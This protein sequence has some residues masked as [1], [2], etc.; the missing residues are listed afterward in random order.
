ME[1]SAPEAPRALPPS[2][3]LRAAC[4]RLP[5]HCGHAPGKVLLTGGYLVLD[6]SF[7]GM[8]FSLS[9]RFHCALT[10]LASAELRAAV[11][12]PSPARSLEEERLCVAASSS[13]HDLLALF[14]L[15]A[16]QR[17]A[18][19]T[20]YWVRIRTDSGDGSLPFAGSTSVQRRPLSSEDN[21]FVAAALY[22]G[23]HLLSSMLPA[24]L[25][26][27]RLGAPLLLTVLGDAAF[28]TAE[29]TE[30]VSAVAPHARVD[31]KTGLGS[32]A[33]LVAS[34]VA[35]LFQVFGLL[36]AQ[37]PPIVLPVPPPAMD[38]SF[39]VVDG[40]GDGSTAQPSS[41]RTP[42]LSGLVQSSAAQLPLASVFSAPSSLPSSSSAAA[43]LCPPCALSL[44][45]SA[46]VSVA[47][48]LSQV[49]HTIA[50][51]KVGSGFDVAA[52]FYGSHV[53]T[54]FSPRCIQPLLDAAEDAQRTQS[55]DLVDHRIDR[56]LLLRALLPRVDH[57]QERQRQQ[58][59]QQQQHGGE[60]A[61]SQQQPPSS[62]SST[63]SS[64]SLSRTPSPLMPLQCPACGW[65][66][67]GRVEW[68][69]V[70]API[71]LPSFLEL[72]LVDV[73]GGAKTPSMVQAVLS[74]RKRS[75]R[76]A[77]DLWQRLSE[78]VLEAEQLLRAMQRRESDALQAAARG[79]G[80]G[81]ALL[82]STALRLAE[83]TAAQ[84]PE[85][86]LTPSPSTAFS[87]AA[88]DVP[89]VQSL[90]ALHARFLRIRAL[91]RAMGDA[92]GVAIEPPGQTRLCD[93]TMQQPGVLAAVVPG[94]GGEDAIAVLAVRGATSTTAS[95]SCT[96]RLIDAWQRFSAD[97]GDGR[98]IRPLPVSA[99]SG[100]F[101][102]CSSAGVQH[103]SIAADI[104]AWAI[105]RQH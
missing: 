34:L 19:L 58:Q 16:P 32:S 78:A 88:V 95:S 35:A 28:Y 51:G 8:V 13:P 25:L 85:L 36:D 92:C 47:H 73:Q 42:G 103:E 44:S 53:Y 60:G 1:S 62:P 26:R 38:A 30:T 4:A 31:G 86:L 46:R 20:E 55:A 65:L 70:I 64:S 39:V 96:P 80:V 23:L 79:V 11:L 61:S 3:P 10:P 59:Q 37:L 29:V 15:H 94:A 9:A 71:A 69:E 33:T 41:S 12:T 87:A 84:W 2:H 22:Y 91:Y 77:D 72:L 17:C 83:R 63:R 89:L 105:F 97:S 27:S 5:T 90:L 21:A 52:A 82:R 93:W 75:P 76:E 6:R 50:Q 57:E 74:W 66:S 102:E 67:E 24:A 14:L 18:G 45:L 54:R 104:G 49:V 7:S 68:D 81:L 56:A 100:D 48:H 99:L 40:D 101:S 43:P 98:V